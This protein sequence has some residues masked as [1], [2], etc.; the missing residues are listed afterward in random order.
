LVENKIL[1]ENNISVT[2]EDIKD[3]IRQFFVKNYFGSFNQ[4]EIQDRLNTLIKD[5][6]KNKE[7]VRNIYDQ[8][9]DRQ[10]K[11]VFKTQMKV[12]IK[13]GD[14]QAFM[15]EINGDKNEKAATKKAKVKK[16]ANVKPASEILAAEP[17]TEPKAKPAAKKAKT[18]GKP[19]T[20]KQ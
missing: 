13:T 10:M 4:E 2:E 17:K 11:E 3:H 15:E 8:L 5:A 12:K 7:D 18:A 14:M 19:K 20:E 16:S 6:M 1:K 9:V